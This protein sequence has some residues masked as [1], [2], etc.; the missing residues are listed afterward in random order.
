MA[1]TEK[2]ASEHLKENWNNVNSMIGFLGV[3]KLYDFYNRVLTFDQIRSILST[4]ESYSLMSLVHKTTKS[5]PTIAHHK[6]DVIQIEYVCISEFEDF[7]DGVKFL[8]CGID[9]FTKRAWV[10]PCLN[11]NADSSIR[12]IALLFNTMKIR[13]KTVLCDNGKEFNN[14]KF[15]SYL[16]KIGVNIIFS[17]SNQKASTVERFQRTLQRKIYTYLTEYEVLRYIDVLQSIITTYNI[18]KHSFLKFSPIQVETSTKVHN[19]ILLKHADKF[20][21]IKPRKPKFIVGD[22]VRISVQKTA[23]HRSYNLQ[24][25]YERFIIIKVNKKMPIPRYILSDENGC[26][27]EGFFLEFELIRVNIQKYR[28]HVIGER[29]KNKKREFLL[30]FKGYSNDFNLWQTKND[31]D[32][33]F[34]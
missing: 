1:F 17:Q 31:D 21:K 30:K 12:S 34:S 27:I 6:R 3:S 28:A 15:R 24:R 5:Y 33:H 32:H 23:F 16:S 9:V 19:R 20:F 8:F 4:F 10:F 14:K 2:S 25:T 18:T 7:N 29:V 11:C 22:I 26:E 13:H